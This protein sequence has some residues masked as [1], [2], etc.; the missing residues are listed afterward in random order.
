MDALYT[1]EERLLWRTM[2]EFADAEIAPNAARWDANEE[3]P[4]ASVEAMRRTGLMGMTAKTEH[5]G[6]GASYAELAIA[7]EEIARVCLASSTTL[8]AHLSLGVSTLDRFANDEQASRY[9]PAAATGEEIVSWALSEPSSGSDAADMQTTAVRRS[10]DC[11]VLNGSKIFITNAQESSLMVVFTATDRALGHRGT[12]ALV[13]DTRLPGVEMRPM[14]GKLGIRGSGT[15][16]VYFTDVEV[17]AAD[18]L[19]E[20]GEG[21]RIAMT[22]LD[23][24]RISLAAQSVG[25]AQG[26]FE[27]AVRY[28][29]QRET[30]GQPLKE[31][32]AI[33]FMLS[34]M[35]TQID[36]ARLLTRRAAQLKDAHLPHSRESAM[37]KLH[38]SET[39]HLCVDK[40]LQI[41]GGYGYFREN[42][43]ERMYRDQRITEIYEGSSEIQRIVIARSLLKDYA[44]D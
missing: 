17:P 6:A 43:I 20:E 19:G 9:F 27:A 13:V 35:A 44:V 28:A 16:E 34:D 4:W 31:R 40:G 7:A 30:F 23:S 15:A 10:D 26:A 42:P 2:R 32:Q 33:Q 21:F 41:F 18:R 36:A 8:L 29:Q 1:E 24:S 38:A 5:G 14:R 11:Y 12:T 22:I 37:A 25:L 3:F 39:A